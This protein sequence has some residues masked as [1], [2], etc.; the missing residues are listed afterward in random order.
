M[1]ADAVADVIRR[2][3]GDP[4]SDPREEV[5]RLGGATQTVAK[6]AAYVQQ[7]DHSAKEMMMAMDLLVYADQHKKGIPILINLAG[8]KKEEET[9][10]YAVHLLGDEMGGDPRAINVFLDVLQRKQE[11]QRIRIEAI[12]GLGYME[13]SRG[14]ELLIV[15]LQDEDDDIAEAAHW[16]LVRIN[17]PRAI[18][19]LSPLIKSKDARKREAA[20]SVIE[21]L[22]KK[23]ESL[24]NKGK[25][26]TPN[27]AIDSDEE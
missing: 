23:A 3:L 22:G 26:K 15:E 25:E 17:D 21:Q 13:E 20:K 24:N 14:V 11:S 6:V 8:S 27:K 12:N 10:W 9:R 2:C 19:L 4:P 18:G 5:A 1:Y 7:R 16:A